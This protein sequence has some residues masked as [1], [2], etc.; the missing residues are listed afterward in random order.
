[1]DK[2]VNVPL[3]LELGVSERG[4]VFTGPNTRGKTVALKTVMLMIFP[5]Y[6][7]PWK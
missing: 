4:I 7:I 6:L 3:D 2:G 1:M 5:L